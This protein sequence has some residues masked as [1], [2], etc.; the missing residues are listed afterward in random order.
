MVTR[1]T[2]S[3][4][5]GANGSVTS[6]QAARVE[7]AVPHRLAAKE[8]RARLD[9]TARRLRQVGRA[10]GKLAR[11]SMHEVALAAKACRTPMRSIWRNVASAGRNIA[12]DATAAWHEV[13][14]LPRR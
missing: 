7:R 9:A 5:R 2:P 14:R 12:R 13:A 11:N 3:K 4:R 8:A 1:R 10:T 6:T